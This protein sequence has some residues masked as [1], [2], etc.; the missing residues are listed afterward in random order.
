MGIRTL[1]VLLAIAGVVWIVARLRR[2]RAVPPPENKPM[3]ARM[4][5]CAH[6]GLHVPAKEAVE[7]PD[8]WYCSASHRDRGP[9]D[10]R[11]G[12]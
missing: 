11:P 8:G 9:G 4:I 7:G 1:L 5:R 3:V 10:G 6:C 12:G 2:Q